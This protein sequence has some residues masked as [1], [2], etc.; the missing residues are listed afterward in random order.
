MTQYRVLLPDGWYRYPVDGDPKR[1]SRAFADRHLVLLGG[2]DPTAVEA[3]RRARDDISS[4]FTTMADAG[5]T[6]LYF[7]DGRFGGAPMNMLFT[8]GVVYLGP[9]IAELELAEVA[10]ALGA[11]TT[12]T[13]LPVGAA[14][15]ARSEGE[16]DGGGPLP[17]SLPRDLAAAFLA[18]SGPD[19]PARTTRVDYLL[20]VPQEHGSFA[21]ISFQ[22]A[23]ELF[24]DE[25]VAHFD[26][27]M[28]GFAW[29]SGR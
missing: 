18:G 26:I 12:L 8:I 1:A 10:P 5:T 3:R 14:L 24:T 9:T 23:G 13:D 21:L 15:R 16:L 27:L 7:F 17:A 29:E 4:A 2:D 28:T 19:V 11:S 6:D 22:C 25:R 20:P